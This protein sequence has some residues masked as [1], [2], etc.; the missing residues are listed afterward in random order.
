M[1]T[2]LNV[3]YANKEAAKRFFKAAPFPLVFD[4]AIKKWYVAADRVAVDAYVAENKD[5]PYRGCFKVVRFR[6]TDDDRAVEVN[7]GFRG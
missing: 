7:F 6:Y 1:R 4:G 5:N 3:S 2:Y